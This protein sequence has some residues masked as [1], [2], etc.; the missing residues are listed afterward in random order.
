VFAGAGVFHITRCAKQKIIS[1]REVAR[2]AKII[3]EYS[4]L[5]T[6]HDIPAKECAI[7]I[8]ATLDRVTGNIL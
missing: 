4:A 8:R 2:K 1:P 3:F 5:L 6:Y 7:A